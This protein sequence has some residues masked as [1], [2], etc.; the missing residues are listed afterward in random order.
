[1]FKNLG[2]KA[3][4]LVI[5]TTMVFSL[6]QVNVS[7]EEEETS[8][9]AVWVAV[10]SLGNANTAGKTVS[11]SKKVMLVDEGTTAT[12]AFIQA[13]EK[14][15]IDYTA[16]VQS[17]GTYITINEMDYNAENGKYWDFIVNG[18]SSMVGTDAYTVKEGDKL[19]FAYRAFGDNTM[20]ASFTDDASLNP[21]KEQ[22]KEY[23]DIAEKQ[24]KLLAEN[25][26]SFV[27]EEG[28][29]KPSLE[30]SSS[31]YMVTMLKKC[32]FEAEEF[33]KASVENVLEELKQMK[34]SEEAFNLKTMSYAVEFLS[35]FGY[36]C[37]DIEGMN[38]VA[39]IT[40]LGNY[41]ASYY[42]YGAYGRDGLILK[43]LDSG[44]YDLSQMSIESNVSRDLLIKTIIDDY[45]Y[46]V[47]C[48]ESYDSIDPLSMDLDAVAPY[49][50]EAYAKAHNVTVPQSE[51]KDYVTKALNLIATFQDENGKYKAFGYPSYNSLGVSMTAIGKAGVNVLD[52]SN[53]YDFIKNGKT[54]IDA[55]SEF[56]DVDINIIAEGVFSYAPEQLLEGIYSVNKSIVIEDSQEETTEVPTTVAPTTV[57]P[58]TAS[59]TT[60]TI[61]PATKVTK[62]K[63]AK[64]GKKVKLTFKKVKGVDGYQVKIS[65]SKKFPKKD[66]TFYTS[67]KPT[68][69]IKNLKAK[70]KYYVKVRA[71]IVISKNVKNYSKWSKV[72]VIKKK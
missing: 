66:T 34:D 63:R 7:A 59:V 29:V 48:V 2:K 1:M 8:K 71:Y 51:I 49:M 3:M 10:D 33:Y 32:G 62:V 43:A 58:T 17:W 27:F 21:N 31:L 57:A 14:Y 20:P 46:A 28:N 40:D 68:K 30:Y 13:F 5:A 61:V 18:E 55:A 9:V 72:T 39:E 4:S 25:M 6:A 69:N 64:N 24:I 50:D 23:K 22:M 36:D 60:K 15:D 52:E 56:V 38:L 53:G 11:L 19:T 47:S 65:K 12:D 45:E 16:S 70:S 37:T 42:S 67:K 35:T 41:E 44:D 54:L 26:Y